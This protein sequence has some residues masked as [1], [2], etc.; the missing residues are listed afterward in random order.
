MEPQ[1]SLVRVRSGSVA[2]PA[3]ADD[4]IAGLVRALLLGAAEQATI[5]VAAAVTPA[6]GTVDPGTRARAAAAIQGARAGTGAGT[7]A[8]PVARGCN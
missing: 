3:L 8:G 4:H 2:P 5:G 6:Q 1:W 7:G